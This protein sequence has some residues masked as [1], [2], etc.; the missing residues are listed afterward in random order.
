MR[1]AGRAA[2]RPVTKPS[3]NN[4]ATNKP[5]GK[6]SSPATVVLSPHVVDA[7]NDPELP[8]LKADWQWVIAHYGKPKNAAEEFDDW[9]H[10]CS[11]GPHACTGKFPA[12]FRAT[13]N[14]AIETAWSGIKL[15]LGNGGNIEGYYIPLLVGGLSA[16]KIL[17]RNLV[18]AGYTEPT[19]TKAE[20]HHIVAAG[21][22]RAQEARDVLKA[23]DIGVNDTPNGVWLSRQQ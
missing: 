1:R 5:K 18:A 10:A 8:A 7:T 15:G 16:A 17:G 3:P 4:L 20:A 2:A 22:R 6:A 19:Y 14:F 12:S 9:W 11:I 23:F 13:P 21:N